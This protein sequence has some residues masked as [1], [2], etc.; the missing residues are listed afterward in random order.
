MRA[1]LLFDIPTALVLAA[2][3]V[4][5]AGNAWLYFHARLPWPLHVLVGALGIHLAFTVWHEAVHR[6]ASRIGWLNDV[7]GVLGALPYMAPFYLE[8][9]FH[10]QHHA[11]LNR[12]D[13]P[14]YIYTDG[15]LWRLPLRYVRILDYARR[16]M[17]DDPRSPL[18]RWIDRVPLAL[19]LAL[20][21]TALWR[22]AL[23]DLIVLWALPFAVSKLVMDWYINW[24]PHVGLPPDRY[25]GTRIVDVAWLTPLV[26][27]HNYHAI[28]HL[29]PN[30]PWHRYRPTFREK[31]AS[32]RARGVPVETRLRGWST[33]DAVRRD[34]VSG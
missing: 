14:N 8:K 32:L 9:W 12:S 28:H 34:S 15:P 19:V 31:Q 17:R 10:L 25:R 1:K 11:L 2:M 5:L 6:N 33:H 26:L 30:L 3:Y 13:D 24:L 7:F 23:L 29:W 27:A 4:L 16:R 18:E 20:V 22:G 21:G